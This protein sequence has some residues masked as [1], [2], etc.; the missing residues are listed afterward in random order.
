MRAS[1]NSLLLTLLP[2]VLVVIAAG[3]WFDE[4][5]QGEPVSVAKPGAALLLLVCCRD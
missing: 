4:V 3:F 2:L 5:Q 1:L